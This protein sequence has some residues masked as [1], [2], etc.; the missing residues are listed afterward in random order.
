MMINAFRAEKPRDLLR[1]QARAVGMILKQFADIAYDVLESKPDSGAASGTGRDVIRPH[2]VCTIDGARGSGKTYTLLS[3]ENVIQGLS[4]SWGSAD[5]FNPWQSVLDRYIGQSKLGALNH[6]KRISPHKELAQ[7]LSIIFPGDME[8]RESLMEAIFASMMGKLEATTQDSKNQDKAK[9]LCDKLRIEV[10]QGWYFSK[11]FGHDSIVRDSID[12]TDYIQKLEAE[13]RKAAKRIDAWRSFI[14][15][16]LDVSNV[17][18]LAI[19]VDD[20]DVR[21]ELTSDILHSIRMFLNH[22]RLLTVLAGNI[23]SMRS[24]LVHQAVRPLGQSMRALAKRDS[25]TAN[26]W[27][28]TERKAVEDYLEKILP[29]AHRFFIS[30]PSLQISQSSPSDEERVVRQKDLEKDSDFYKILGKTFSH[31]CARMLE[32]TRERFLTEK[33]LLAIAHASGLSDAPGELSR[34]N[35]EAYLAWWV[36]FNRYA[37]SLA[38]K[39]ARQIV[40]FREY[41][42]DFIEAPSKDTSHVSSPKRLIIALFEN[43]ANYAL[44]QQFGDEDANVVTWLQHQSLQSTWVGERQFLVNARIINHGQYAYDYLRFRLDVGIAIPARDNAEE[45]VPRAL[46]PELKGRR[47]M[48][49]FFQPPRIPRRQR[50]LGVA[51]WLDHAAIPGNCLYFYDLESLPD[52]SLISPKESKESAVAR[53]LQAGAWEAELAHNWIEA[54]ED[55]QDEFTYRYFTEVVCASQRGTAKVPSTELIELLSPPSPDRERR[56]AG[57]ERFWQD[58]FDSFGENNF[59]NL[60]KKR[61]TEATDGADSLRRRRRR[62]A[63][64]AALITDVRRAW[65]AIRIYEHFPLKTGALPTLIGSPPRSFVNEEERRSFTFIAT[66][67]RLRL[68]TRY[69]IEQLLKGTSWTEQLLTVFSSSNVTTTINKYIKNENSSESEQGSTDWNA[70]LRRDLKEI[71]WLYSSEDKEVEGDGARVGRNR[72][73]RTVVILRIGKRDFT[74]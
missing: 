2:H 20:S 43:P 54:I 33:F 65:H 41:Y 21:P 63:L 66:Q 18:M 38:P 69:Q 6:L 11:S 67:D 12:Y 23:R 55:G 32:R 72:S 35:L 51:R 45:I 27:R 53:D 34:R 1:T 5:E 73:S 31:V 57:Y 10:A 22:P 52:C 42:H 7:V 8:G 49:R 26:D 47:Y 25:Q 62:V 40:T 70:G 28:R 64:Y 74:C 36:F 37:S 30:Q 68:Y 61:R 29:L 15:E 24:I 39:S 46:L 3:L 4:D 60:W 16:Y 71:S 19:M 14:T 50:R 13:T 58:E 59:A 48:R 44:I 17:A 9:A 56:E